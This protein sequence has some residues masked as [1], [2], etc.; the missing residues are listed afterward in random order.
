MIKEPGSAKLMRIMIFTTF[1]CFVVSVWLGY[2]QVRFFYGGV[3]WLIVTIILAALLS[4]S[5]QNSKRME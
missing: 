2:Y 1:L 3:F 5:G 4:N